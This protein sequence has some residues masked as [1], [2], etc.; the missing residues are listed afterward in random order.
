M[1]T[2]LPEPAVRDLLARAA[3]TIEVD[4]VAPLTLTGLPEPRR[5]WLGVVAAA[6]AI[7]AALTGVVLMR[8]R[9]QSA[10][11]RYVAASEHE[12]T[13]G[14]HQMPSLLGYTE[15]E[16]RALLARR[17]V[18]VVVHTEKAVCQVPGQVLTATPAPGARLRPGARVDLVVA[19]GYVADDCLGEVPWNIVWPLIRLA[20]GLPAEVRFADQVSERVVGSDGAVLGSNRIA[21][22]DAYDPDSWNTCGTAGCHSALAGIAQDVTGP[23]GAMSATGNVFLQAS[24]SGEACAL[25]HQGIDGGDQ[26]GIGVWAEVPTDGFFCPSSWFTVHLDHGNRIDAVTYHAAPAPVAHP[27]DPLRPDAVRAAAA[28]AF[29]AWARGDGPAPRFAETVR[30]LVRDREAS[31]LAGPAAAHPLPW[32]RCAERAVFACPGDDPLQILQA[33]PDRVVQTTTRAVMCVDPE[34]TLPEDLATSVGTDL[35]RLDQVEPRSCHDAYAI[36]LWVDATG[37]IYAVDVAATPQP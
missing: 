28:R 12:V 13:Y 17:D 10:V 18:H 1:P 4:P 35:V 20:R 15:V 6:V 14:P 19:G 34:A 5:R 29:V 8:D 37:A 2:E 36:E 30:R 25:L 7:V 31:P 27:V 26:G 23:V 32:S 21:A 3:E 9:D 33:A 16:A 22:A 11:D 24:T